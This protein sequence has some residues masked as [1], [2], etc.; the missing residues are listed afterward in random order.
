MCKT[1]VSAVPLTTTDA[2]MSNNAAEREALVLV[3]VWLLLD[4]LWGLLAFVA[5]AVSLAA[6]R[7]AIRLCRRV[8]AP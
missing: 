5:I 3:A 2:C 4:Y 1:V 6:R 7:A 8:G